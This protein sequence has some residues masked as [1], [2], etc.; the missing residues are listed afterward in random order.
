VGTRGPIPNG[1][2]LA[3]DAEAVWM[4]PGPIVPLALAGVQ[5]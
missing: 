1:S 2:L 3:V 4:P 5:Q